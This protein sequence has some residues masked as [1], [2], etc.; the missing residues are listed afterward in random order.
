[1]SPSRGGCGASA[2]T[3]RRSRRGGSRWTRA[4]TSSRSARCPGSAWSVGGS[5]TAPPTHSS[6][7]PSSRRRTLPI[8]PPFG[9]RRPRRTARVSVLWECLVGRRLF[10]GSTYAVVLLDV[11]EKEIPPP[12]RFVR[13]IPPEVDRAVLRL[14]ERDLDRRPSSAVAYRE[15][16]DL[17]F[18]LARSP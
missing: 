16:A 5:S 11:I 10:D 2:P 7:S 4:P 14:L 15:L 8:R 13:G 9:G 17:A 6:S 18:R 3:W 12:S 1:R